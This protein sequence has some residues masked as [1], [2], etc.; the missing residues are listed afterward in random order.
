M[1][2]V[3]T[4]FLSKIGEENSIVDFTAGCGMLLLSSSC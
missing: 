1:I 3:L 2:A 4:I